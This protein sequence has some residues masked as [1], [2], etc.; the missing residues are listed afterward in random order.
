MGRWVAFH[1]SGHGREEKNL[2]HPLGIEPCFPYCMHYGDWATPDFQSYR[3]KLRGQVRTLDALQKIEI[4]LCSAMGTGSRQQESETPDEVEKKCKCY[5]FT[6]LRT[7]QSTDVQM[8]V[9][10][11]SKCTSECPDDQQ[12]NKGTKSVFSWHITHASWN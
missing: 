7:M 12:W 11:T 1:W 2:L 4:P 6:H 5:H 8:Q 3:L 10:H 9:L